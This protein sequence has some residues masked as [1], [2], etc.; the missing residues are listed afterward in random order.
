METN[1]SVKHQIDGNKFVIEMATTRFTYDLVEIVKTLHP[2]DEICKYNTI[3]FN[4]EQVKMIDSTSI[5]F[6]FEL[7]NK[8]KNES[9]NVTL[10]ISLGNNK[11]LKSLLHKFQVDLMLNIQ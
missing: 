4:L 11:E 9:T 7:H 2:F 3:E 5:G 1:D 6:L 8:L 10:V